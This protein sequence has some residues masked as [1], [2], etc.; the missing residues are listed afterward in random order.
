MDPAF[1]FFN[2]TATTE[3]YTLSLHDAL[4]ICLL[5]CP[6]AVAG[7]DA[8][9]GTRGRP[10]RSHAP[11]PGGGGCHFLQCIRR[12]G[13]CA[14]LEPRPGGLPT[15]GPVAR[16]HGGAA[17]RPGFSALFGG[18][19]RTPPA[20]HRARWPPAGGPPCFAGAPPLPSCP[21]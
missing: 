18:A 6:G 11:C 16:R 4:P 8:P 14:V 13:P 7:P 1:F 20:R 3:I 17:L 19:G 12:L 21:P 15:A 5:H 10:G 2:D 9:R